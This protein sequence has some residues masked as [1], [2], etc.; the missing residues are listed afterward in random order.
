MVA[1]DHHLQQVTSTVESGAGNCRELVPLHAAGCPQ[2]CC[3]AFSRTVASLSATVLPFHD[4]FIAA[5]IVEWILCLL[6][7]W[8]GKAMK[9]C[10]DASFIISSAGHQIVVGQAH[11]LCCFCGPSSTDNATLADRPYLRFR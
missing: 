9:H 6:G 5:T 7:S 4:A 11:G 3:M 2:H 8:A 10:L 1:F